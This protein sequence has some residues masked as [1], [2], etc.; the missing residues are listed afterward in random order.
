LQVAATKA[1]NGPV[2]F[3]RERNRTF[4]ERRDVVVKGL[5]EIGLEAEMPKATFY[6]W[7]SVPKGYTSRDF[8]F[9]MLDEINVWMI[10]GSMYGKYGEGYLRIALTHPVKRLAEAMGRLKKAMS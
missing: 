9:K 5:R 8:C 2:D 7:S 4:Q 6:V 10:P 1:L 3:M